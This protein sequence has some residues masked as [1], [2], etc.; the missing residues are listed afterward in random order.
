MDSL[1]VLE[2]AFKFHLR[3]GAVSLTT[4]LL[5][6]GVISAGSHNTHSLHHFLLTIYEM[7]RTFVQVQVKV[8]RAGQSY[9]YYFMIIER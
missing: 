1:L 8:L 2:F 9:N 3:D 5:D 4:V 7:K 6:S